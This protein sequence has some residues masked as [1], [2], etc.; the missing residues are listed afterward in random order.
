MFYKRVSFIDDSN[1]LFVY[2]LPESLTP[3]Q[4]DYFFNE[5]LKLKG[6]WKEVNNVKIHRGLSV[7]KYKTLFA[8]KSFTEEVEI[9][10]DYFSKYKSR[11]AIWIQMKSYACKY[12]YKKGMI[13]ADI[14][15]VLG[16]KHHTSIIYFISYY[17]D[18]DRR[19]KFE[20]FIDMVKDEVYPKYING[21][22]EY[23]KL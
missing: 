8:P 19:L 22:L 21:K 14:T 7:S 12:L 15:E 9:I 4:I 20:D 17:K 2:K 18:F 16:Y 1:N 23:V 11:E 13:M 5:Y 3:N 10:R 6:V